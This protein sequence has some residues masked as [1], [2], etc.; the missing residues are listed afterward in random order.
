LEKPGSEPVK[1]TKDTGNSKSFEKAG[2]K[3]EDMGIYNLGNNIF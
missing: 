3:L 2:L 1:I